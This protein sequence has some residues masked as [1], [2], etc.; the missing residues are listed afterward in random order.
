M[1]YEYT[2]SAFKPNQYFCRALHVSTMNQ[3][4]FH[5]EFTG[6]YIN[7]SRGF[8]KKTVPLRIVI[9]SVTES[10]QSVRKMTGTLGAH[11]DA[12]IHHIGAW[13]F[14]SKIPCEHKCDIYISRNYP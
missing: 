8:F 1:H 5:C 12:Y 6:K 9:F 4:K 3:H 10:M 11:I 2:L 13:R 7:L 14:D